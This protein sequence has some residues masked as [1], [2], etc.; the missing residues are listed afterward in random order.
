MMMRW[1]KGH[2]PTINT[3]IFPFLLS[4]SLAVN[5]YNFFWLD[6]II[7]LLLAWRLCDHLKNSA[8]V[9]PKLLIANPL[10]G[11]LLLY[12]GAGIMGYILQGDLHYKQLSEILSMRWIFGFYA[13][14]FL[15]TKISSPMRLHLIFAPLFLLILA[16]II[17][18]IPEA[19]RAEFTIRS[20]LAGF[21]ENPNHLALVLTCL[22]SFVLSLVAGQT[23][24]SRRT[25]TILI[26]GLF[27]IGT[28]ALATYSR[29]A[30]I[31]MLASALLTLVYFKNNTSLKVT[32]L[33]IALF[34][35]TILLN[36]LGFQDRFMSTFDLSVGGS[37]FYRTVFW[38]TSWQI[39][40]DNPLFGVGFEQVSRLYPEY[41]LKMNFPKDYA[42]GHSHNQYLEVLAGTGI[43]GFFGFMGA[44]FSATRFFLQRLKISMDPQ[45]KQ[46]AFGGFL[47]IATLMSCSFT[48]TPVRLQE[49]RNYLMILLGFSYGFLKSR[50]A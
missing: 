19:H 37:Q 1:P 17:H 10:H 45:Q 4:A 9:N 12:V 30:L 28:A 31:G 34:T 25:R 26:S 11:F 47:V 13:F 49:V 24:Q 6:P 42:I 14:S 36:I 44:F 20:R 43:L 3:L 41:Y 21:Y 38:K 8:P 48:E 7:V 39:F 50:I 35:A 46:I 2:T 32:S 29:T 33:I 23:N 18:H 40:L 27:L 22:W 5:F 15:G 16:T